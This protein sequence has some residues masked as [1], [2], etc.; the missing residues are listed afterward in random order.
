MMDVLPAAKR[1]NPGLVLCGQA[2]AGGG[3]KEG[4]EED[5]LECGQATT[6]AEPKEKIMPTEASLILLRQQLHQTQQLHQSLSTRV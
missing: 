2:T 1:F 3:G 4:D 5:G 6:G